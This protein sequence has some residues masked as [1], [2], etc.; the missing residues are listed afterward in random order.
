MFEKLSLCLFNN[1]SLINIV[2]LSI[3]LLTFE[4]IICKIINVK[5]HIQTLLAI[6]L[7]YSVVVFS[8]LGSL[9][10]PETFWQPNINNEYIIFELPD[11]TNIT[12]IL[13]FSSL[14]DTN[15]NLNYNQLYLKDISLYGSNDLIT[16]GEV[17]SFKD[18]TN[19]FMKWAEINDISYNYKYIKLQS[20]SSTSVI[21]ELGLYDSN[22]E[23]IKL[24]IY[25]V[26][27]I[28]NKFKPENITDEAHTIP[29]VVTY[30]NESYF[31]EIYHVRNALETKNRQ[32]L[33]PHVHPLLGTHMISLGMILFGENPFGYRF[34]GAFVSVISLLF[35]YLLANKLF[36]NNK[37]SLLATGLFA[38]DFMHLTTARIA[39][40]E[41]FSILTIIIMYYFLLRF[42]ELDFLTTD[43]KILLKRLF[44]AGLFMGIS[45]ATKWTGMYASVGLALI[46]FNHLYINYKI[47]INNLDTYSLKKFI[48]K[49]ILVCASCLIFFVLIPLIIYLLAYIPTVLQRDDYETIW[50][51]INK[52]Y[53][54]TMGIFNYHNDLVVEKPH[55]FASNWIQWIFDV[56]PIWYFVKDIDGIRY[57]ISNFNNPF[58]SWVGIVSVI[59]TIYYAFIKNEFNAKVI[60]FGYLSSLIPNIIITRELYAYHY[61]PAYPFLILAICFMIN[62]I[63]SKNQ[64]FKKLINIF[65]IGSTLIFILFL[66][67]L[68]GYATTFDYINGVLRWFES[69][70]F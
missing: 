57:S 24:K 42:T 3:I 5:K 10:M 19:G 46:F 59:Y 1:G 12:R 18:T 52:V 43:T 8:N 65:I 34:M 62:K 22:N 70:V 69:W 39:T 20:K 55:P 7:V 67:V 36:V 33:S 49:V 45:W 16:W 41:P 61:F 38:L 26:S 58:I 51:F 32:L 9:K 68:C 23:I 53:N 30:Y 63:Y 11:N 4:F 35:I 21:N 6:L 15:D 13:A 2:F 66:P 44:I 27:N 47:C 50:Q 25:E 37:L 31:D 54:T 56:R 29:E 60:S 17:I 64:M 28:N 48:K 40:L 14:G